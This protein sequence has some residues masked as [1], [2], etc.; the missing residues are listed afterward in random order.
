MRPIAE[1]GPAGGLVGNAPVAS[2]LDLDLDLEVE[3]PKAGGQSSRVG[4]SQ[5]ET[6]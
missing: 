3:V 4:R 5:R 6:S 2:V 1:K